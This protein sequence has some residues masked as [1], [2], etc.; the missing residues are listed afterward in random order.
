M[1]LGG[2]N[3][4]P[5]RTAAAEPIDAAAELLALRQKLAAAHAALADVVASLEA[6]SDVGVFRAPALLANLQAVNRLLAEIARGS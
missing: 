6:A 1:E 2:V 3:S 5:V 4:H